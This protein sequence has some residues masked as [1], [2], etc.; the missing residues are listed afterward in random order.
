MSHQQ[1]EIDTSP[2]TTALLIL[3]DGS[4]NA[5]QVTVDVQAT[6]ANI[7]IRCYSPEHSTLIPLLVS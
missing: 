5:Y 6:I 1:V 7:Q 2:E 3:Q 4:D